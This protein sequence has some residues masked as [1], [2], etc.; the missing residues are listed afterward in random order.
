[1]QCILSVTQQGA[2]RD[3]ASVH[4]HTSIR[5]M[6]IL[7]KISLE[8]LASIFYVRHKL[9]YVDITAVPLVCDGVDEDE[10]GLFCRA[11]HH[12]EWH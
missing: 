3:A 12:R 6:D 8:L 5:R 10:A 9:T 1:M 11:A 7:V 4:F 2:A